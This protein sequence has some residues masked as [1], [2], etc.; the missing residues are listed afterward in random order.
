MTMFKLGELK[1]LVHHL[2]RSDVRSL[3]FTKPGFS[4]R[5]VTGGRPPQRPAPL[6]LQAGS[7]PPRSAAPDKFDV[8]LKSTMIGVFM[9]A[10]P[11]RPARRTEEGQHVPAE[12]VLGLIRVAGGIFRAVRAPCAG[13]IIERAVDDGE[14][15][16]FGTLLFRVRP[17]RKE[18]A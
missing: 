5:V 3:S 1:R 12:E 6:P 14:R 11:S 13:A 16:Q 2:E 17:D 4:L 8:D 10:H 18:P 7:A 9:A 15:V